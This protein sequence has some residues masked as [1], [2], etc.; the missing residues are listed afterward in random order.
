[1][2]PDISHMTPKLASDASTG[3]F[4]RE[5]RMALPA[6]KP[7]SEWI[8]VDQ[9]LTVW[10]STAAVGAFFFTEAMPLSRAAAVL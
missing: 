6:P 8:V 5:P 10:S 1:M 7:G 3:R 2:Q 4:I 9:V